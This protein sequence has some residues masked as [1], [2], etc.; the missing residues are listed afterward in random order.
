M[1]EATRTVLL[2]GRDEPPQK[3]RVLRAGPLTAE[4]DGVDL[5]YVRAGGVEIVRRL[6][7]AIRDEVWGTVPAQLE[8]VH[9]EEG[10]RSFH[11]SFDALHEA[12]ALRYRWHGELTGSEDGTIECRM[13]GKAEQAF[14]FCRIGFCVLHP[15]ENAGRPYR[16]GTPDG[17][18]QGTLPET[19]GMQKI[20]NG[21]LFPLFPSYRRLEL[22][23]EDGLTVR[24]DFEGDLFEM[25]D[26]R[27]WTDASFKTYSTPITL[28]F[29]H[30]APAGHEIAQSVRLAVDLPAADDAVRLELGQ[31][32]SFLPPFGLVL[33]EEPGERELERLLALRLDH[34]RV[35]LDLDADWRTELD[36][37]GSTALSLGAALEVVL[38]LGDE[39][40]L[41]ELAAALPLAQAKLARVLVLA[42]DKV[43][44]DAEDVRRVREKLGAAAG[45]PSFGAGTDLWFTELNRTRPELEGVDGV[46]YST[47]ATVHAD[48]DASVLETP[49]TQAD[50]VRSARAIAGGREVYV[51]PITI[52]PRS[53][54]FGELH[55]Y[56]GLPFQVDQRQPAL[57]GAAWT[58]AS[59]K[60]VAE[61]RASSATYFET[62]GWRGVMERELGSEAPD[63]FRSAPGGLFPLYHVLADYGEWRGTTVLVRCRSSQPLAVEAL[64]ART[65]DGHHLLVANL[66]PEPQRC[67]IGPLETRNVTLRILAE[68]TVA[69]AVQDP[70]AFRAGHERSPVREGRIELELAPYAVVRVDP[71]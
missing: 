61:A 39:A 16:A 11:V 44:S 43:V 59:L 28:G 7:A 8:S 38:R 69:E 45:A 37:A 71:A 67:T 68:T 66:T 4:L 36:R 5:R 54:P 40:Q 6:F 27:N 60:H 25:E 3:R 32:E 70:D 64:A 65:N 9:V 23:L 50:T 13:T 26:Q 51:G 19:I 48:D 31:A 17:P 34:L 55:G 33:G 63:V 47:A 52:R 20:E 29:P 24:F 49:A 2:V 53:W 10:E 58:A 14:R 56:G 46:F 18:I 22:D 41:D 57:V 1:G 62:T 30:D 42:K 15:R 35:E 21:K 12:G